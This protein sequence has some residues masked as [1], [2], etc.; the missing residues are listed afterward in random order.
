MKLSR[1]QIA[2]W[3]L[4]LSLAGLLSALVA[5]LIQRQFSLIVQISLAVVV[6]GIA[7][8]A[9][10][11][12]QKLREAFTGRQARYASNA[13]ILTVSFIGILII[14]NY[15]VYKNSPRWDLTED[16]VHTLAP[17][18]I[19]TLKNLPAPV[20]ALAFF[21]QSA[22]N[23]N[24]TRQILESY[25]YNAP[26]KFSYEF[27]NPE[28]NPIAV[29]NANVTRDGTI[30]LQMGD[31]QELISYPTEQEITSAL[32]KLIHP[33][34]RVLYFL[35]GHGEKDPFGTTDASYSTLRTTLESKNY[36][37]QALNLIGQPQIPSNASAIIVA[38]PIKPLSDSEISTLKTYLD[39]GGSVI[40]LLE[41][42]RL[43]E[44]TQGWETLY[45]YLQSSWGLQLD[46]S[47]VVNPNDMF[48]RVIA[49]GDPATYANHPITTNLQGLVT[50][51]PTA[52][53]IQTVITDQ[54]VNVTAVISTNAKVSWAESN[55]ASL[56][57]GN[58]TLDS[59]DTPGPLSVV[60][61]GEHYMSGARIVVIGD[62]DFAVNAAFYQY[63]NGD[64]LVNSIDWANKQ[65][66]II[67]LTPKTTT[68]RN[69]IP[70]TT[71]GM[72][73][74]F[75]AVFSLPVLVIIAGIVVW[76]RRRQKG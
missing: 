44:Q 63:G 59:D 69:L 29:Q 2:P 40:F 24:E 39:N 36:T 48:D 27:I 22:Y 73:I 60:V 31:R 41:P 23:T 57:K 53:A 75:L 8:F 35:N 3:C 34:N 4:Y 12:P 61:A 5:Y 76:I 62:A 13:T 14:T 38:G 65:E 25:Q 46:D 15:L 43:T 19:D 45:Q 66:N 18:T 37:V 11:D 7:L 70:P 42:R 28:Q 55:I 64:L 51:F 71:A 54:P 21:S 17:E 74:I 56:E 9:M 47:I 30:V 68:Q 33:E 58:E 26:N 49:I 32:I 1:K 72:A 52:Q 67:T 6:L 10:L 16:Q 20:K 50:L